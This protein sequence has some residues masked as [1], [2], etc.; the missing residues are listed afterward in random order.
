MGETFKKNQFTWH[1]NKLNY[2]RGRFYFD[3]S[4]SSSYTD[5][6]KSH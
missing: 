3:L 2:F 5:T 4:W 1:L 6:T